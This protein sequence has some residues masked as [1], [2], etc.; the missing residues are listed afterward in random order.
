MRSVRRKRAVENRI[1][2]HSVSGNINGT[3]RYGWKGPKDLMVIG[4]K[5]WEVNLGGM[6]GKKQGRT[7][8]LGR[9]EIRSR[10]TRNLHRCSYKVVGCTVPFSKCF[11]TLCE[12][13]PIL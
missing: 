3:H 13:K 1:C 2:G 8:Y 4:L 7:K 9:V 6:E 11:L 5:R 12:N 10:K